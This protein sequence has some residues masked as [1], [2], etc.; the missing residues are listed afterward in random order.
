M[1]QFPREVAGEHR[2]P[3]AKPFSYQPPEQRP[4]GG[5]DR[6]AVE[7]AARTQQETEAELM[8]VKTEMK[9]VKRRAAKGTYVMSDDDGEL[10][11]LTI[12][13]V[14]DPSLMATT[15]PRPWAEQR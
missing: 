14:H 10:E 8:R 12:R 2:L 11:D 3:A 6:G 4:P 15:G 13:T 9:E 7:A 5:C 1:F